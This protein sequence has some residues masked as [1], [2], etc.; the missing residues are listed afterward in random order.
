[1]PEDEQALDQLQSPT[2]Q[3]RRHLARMSQMIRDGASLSGQERNCVFLNTRDEKF[4]TVSAVSGLDF[5]DDARAPA[6][7]DWDF[8][9]DLDLWVANRTAPMVRLL[10]NDNRSGNHWL[11]LRLRGVQCNRDAIGARVE[12]HFSDGNPTVTK[13]LH[14]GEGFL[15]QSSKWV[16]FGLGNSQTI[17]GLVI[18]WP[19]GRR[20][21]L[22]A[23]QVDRHYSIVQGRAAVPVNLPKPSLALAPQP[24]ETGH[25]E[26]GSR[27]FISG[28]FPMPRL[29]YVTPFNE[30]QNVPL[31]AG[32][33]VLINLWASWCRNCVVEFSEWTK[34][35]DRLKQSGLAIYVLSIDELDQ[36]AENDVS[37]AY[38]ML[39]RIGLPFER[40]A[41]GESML[42]QLQDAY[43]WPYQ[44][45]FPMSV[46][47]SI[48]FDED[49]ELAAIYR[50]TVPIDQLLSDVSK[51]KLSGN[52]LLD[53]AIPFPG[54]WYHRPAT[55]VPIQIASQLVEQKKLGAAAEY[56]RAN[57]AL[58][59]NNPAYGLLTEWVGE[60]FAK[61]GGIDQAKHFFAEAESHHND[62]FRVLN[63]LAW[64]YAT[65]THETLRYPTKAVQLA[66]RANAVTRESNATVLDT[67]S[68]AYAAANDLPNAIAVAQEA[69]A[70]AEKTGDTT[71]ARALFERIEHW[72]TVVGRTDQQQ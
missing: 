54:R 9:G 3:Y 48:L 39:D 37:V 71:T 60:E 38:A 28:R 52:A 67:L 7:V 12:I 49:G 68:I 18:H 66:Q 29:Q 46:P 50:G 14:A 63:N 32:Q 17:D 31:G 1:M 6:L 2:S 4:A 11:A 57:R 41:C 53:A 42:V 27:V 8:D 64:Q 33:P 59:E 61:I 44:R 19:G 56:V 62:D 35:A 58:L 16:H 47:T 69:R 22:P 43:Q 21:R 23:L 55:R 30:L 13:T 40:G 45:K 70:L 51:L 65:Q 10:R 72:R 34:Q 5:A 24:L 15:A 25:V 36:V 26:S 20:Q